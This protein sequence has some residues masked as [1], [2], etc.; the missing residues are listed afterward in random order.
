MVPLSR[1]LGGVYRRG[2]ELIQESGSL[3]S[4]LRR[5]VV[6]LHFGAGLPRSLALL[7]D[8]KHNAAVLP[9]SEVVL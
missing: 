7:G 1:G 4:L 9:G 5:V 6:Q 2:V 8:P 3:D